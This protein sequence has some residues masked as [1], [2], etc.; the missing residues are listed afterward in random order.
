MNWPTLH[1]HHKPCH[2]YVPCSQDRVMRQLSRLLQS[3]HACLHVISEDDVARM[4]V[5]ERGCVWEVLVCVLDSLL[6]FV[7]ICCLQRNITV[8]L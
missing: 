8:F 1:A 7:I 4:Q 2:L 6:S 3:L 5:C